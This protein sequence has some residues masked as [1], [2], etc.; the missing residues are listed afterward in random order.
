[1][2]NE[3]TKKYIIKELLEYYPEKVISEVMDEY[4]YLDMKTL[5]SKGSLTDLFKKEIISLYKSEDSSL[6]VSIPLFGENI[7]TSFFSAGFHTG[8]LIECDCKNKRAEKIL[9]ESLSKIAP[10]GIIFIKEN[11]H[12]TACEIIKNKIMNEYRKDLAPHI[13]VLSKN[14]VMY[15]DVY[16]FIVFKGDEN[17]LLDES[18]T[19][20][21]DDVI[22]DIESEDFCSSEYDYLFNHHMYSFCF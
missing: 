7:R 17:H 16:S 22:T 13:S 4:F 19:I 12:E 9:K 20:S 18:P 14:A 15:T 21:D 11:N 2:I 3:I 8:F 10:T 1:M 6:V 5:K